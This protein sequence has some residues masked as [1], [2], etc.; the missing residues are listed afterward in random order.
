MCV[1]TQPF[2]KQKRVI[3]KMG[4]RTSVGERLV[5]VSIKHKTLN[6]R[7]ARTR[8]RE[9]VCG[10]MS[11]GGAYQALDPEGGCLWGDYHSPKAYPAPLFQHQSNERLIAWFRWIRTRVTEVVGSLVLTSLM[12]RHIR[13]PS[14]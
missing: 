4:V 11:R 8:M 3:Q 12:S 1:S 6:L 7:T 2:C 9:G 13:H 10:R 5:V 14:G